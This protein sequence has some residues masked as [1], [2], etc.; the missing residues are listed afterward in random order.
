MELGAVIGAAPAENVV[1]KTPC[2]GDIILLLGGATGRDGCGGATGSSKAHDMQSI[3]TCGAE[4]QKGNPLTER[5]LQRL[6]RNREFSAL[7][8][9]CNDFGAG[10]VCVAIGELSGGVR[11]DLDKVRK[12]YEGLGGVELAIS[13]SQERMAVVVAPEDAGKVLELAKRENLHADKV[14]EVTDKERMQLFWRGKPIVDI[15][16]SFLDTNGATSKANARAA[17]YETRDLF[18]ENFSGG[19]YERLLSIVSDIN[20]CSKKGLI[21]MFDS[22]IGAGTVNMPLGGKFQLTPVQAMAAKVAAEG[23]C[24]TA[25]VF[26]YGLDPYL[27]EKNPFIGAIYSVVLSL[28]KLAAAGADS[29][30][31]WLTLQEYFERVVSD[32][33]WGKPLSALLGAWWAQKNL[34][35]AAIGGKDSMSGTFEDIHVPS[36]LVSFAL[37]TEHVDNLISPEFKY[38]GSTIYR[39]R[40]KRDKNG[41]PDFESIKKAYASVYALIKNKKI[42]SAYAVERGGALAAIAKMAL[43]NGIGAHLSGSDIDDLT[44]KAYGDMILEGKGLPFERIG[45]TVRG[46]ISFGKESVAL[47]ELRASFIK[48]LISVYPVDKIQTGSIPCKLYESKNIYTY[49]GTRIRPRI[50]IPVFPGTNCEYDTAAAFKAAGGLPEIFVMRNIYEGDIEYSIDALAQLITYSQILMLPG[51]FSAGDEPD[52][53]GKFITAVLRAPKVKKAVEGLMKRDGLILGVCNGFQALVKVGLVPY[54]EIRDMKDDSPTLTFNSIGRHVSKLVK[55]RVASN[56]SPWLALCRPGD[57]HTI[58]VS[59]G[60]GRFI[61]NEAEAMALYGQGQIA[62]QY[63]DEN[64]L[65]TMGEGNPNGSL[66]AVEGLLSPDG[67]IFG[68]MGHSERYTY[69]TFKNVAGEK[70]QRIFE[71]G[72][73]Y[74]L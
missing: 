34:K 23:E 21:E 67:R 18:K 14:A 53:S 57:I 13:E 63:A 55:T 56:A 10:G 41:M 36:T 28:A 30:G 38:N 17:G 50:V 61:A 2:P 60:E 22:T 15:K 16:R 9:R 62:T 40:I 58:A 46:S 20:V 66:L 72:V 31:A 52:G 68:K 65:P 59:H 47:T 74:F 19:F 24:K 71:S 8:K 73:N 29:S 69:G 7:I 64:G 25:T 44:D 1:R 3:D 27:M 70:D 54:G 32:T 39:V 43:G 42:F 51:G 6:F 12:K 35:V 45:K 33:S 4:V 26:S 11:V 5:K 48:P 37:S 49:T